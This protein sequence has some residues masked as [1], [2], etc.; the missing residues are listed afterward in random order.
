MSVIFNEAS[1]PVEPIANGV[2][3]KRLITPERVKSDN[4]VTEIVGLRPGAEIDISVGATKV[5]WAH[6]LEGQA[7]LV[8][9]GDAH[10]LSGD[11]FLFLPPGFSAR[12]TTVNG[13]RLFKATVP[14]A[15]RFDPAW[16]PDTLAF[17]CVD[18]T[19]EP[20]LNSEFDARKRIYLITPALSASTVVKGEMIIY[21]PGT[22]AANHHHEGA[23]HFQYILRGSA[24]FYLNEQ[25]HRVN[26]GDTV[27]IYE[28]ERHYF[29]NDGDKEMAFVEYFIP[30]KYTTIWAENA[31]ICTW[32][33][34]GLNIKG[35]KPSREIGVHTSMD[36]RNDV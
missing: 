4:V 1:V 32:H 16:A 5:A 3:V 31:P 23:D 25:P 20:V 27:Y 29:I 17:R 13:A 12:L 35:G 10:D 26:A 9:A 36:K 15:Q 24:T 8:D 28:N 34:S 2:S 11:H 18:W 19:R 33:P 22:E 14:D 21:P 6:I 30:G 7:K